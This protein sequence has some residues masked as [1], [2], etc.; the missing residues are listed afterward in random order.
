[1]FHFNNLSLIEIY[2]LNFYYL[3]VL[4]LNEYNRGH[5]S[6]WVTPLVQ[7]VSKLSQQTKHERWS[8]ALD[9]HSSLPC[10]TISKAVKNYN[11]EPSA[12][13]K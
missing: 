7:G 9:K 6:F 8:K 12:I 11:T 13:F 10:Q 1:L 2:F 3:K 5:I 4:Q